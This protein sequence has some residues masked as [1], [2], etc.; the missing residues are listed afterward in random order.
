M[1]LLTTLGAMLVL[2]T[3]AFAQEGMMDMSP[4]KEMSQLSFLVGKWKADLDFY[5]AGPE[6]MKGT[7][8]VETKL[9][10]DGRFYRGDHKY[11]PPGMPAMSGLQLMTFDPASKKWTGWW[12]DGTTPYE[13]E[14]TGE[15]KGNVLT[16]VSKPS[17][18]P[19][20]DQKMVIKLIYEK[21]GDT[22]VKFDLMMQQGDQWAPLIKGTYTKA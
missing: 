16:M 5:F 4:P 14:M 20:S 12:F 9:D 8:T 2:L 19:G 13:L 1:K 18:M 6:P 7:G 3:T 17:S 11:S 15:L 21:V 10:L 22:K